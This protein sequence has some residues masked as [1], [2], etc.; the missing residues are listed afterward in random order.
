MSDVTHFVRARKWLDDPETVI[1]DDLR[2]ELNAA[3]AVS[4]AQRETAAEIRQMGRQLTDAIADAITSVTAARITV[5]G[6]NIAAISG[7]IDE[8]TR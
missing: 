1:P 5:S 8:A 3:L 6:T 7:A 4:V 2:A